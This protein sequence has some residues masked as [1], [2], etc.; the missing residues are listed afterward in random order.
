MIAQ[1]Y[2]AVCLHCGGE[3]FEGLSGMVC[4]ECQ[5]RIIPVPIY[6]AEL[7]LPIRW[8]KVRKLGQ[9]VLRRWWGG[10]E[11]RTKRDAALATLNLKQTEL[12]R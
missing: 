7:E 4:G 2:E 10:G 12:F 8:A 11:S 3:L 5:C 1:P 9:N 6:K